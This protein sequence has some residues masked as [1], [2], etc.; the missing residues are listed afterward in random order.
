MLCY[1]T[2]RCLPDVREAGRNLGI[3][4]LHYGL[5]SCPLIITFSPSLDPVPFHSFDM[6][7]IYR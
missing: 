1:C 4:Y 7:Y 2:A 6:S 3:L 5:S